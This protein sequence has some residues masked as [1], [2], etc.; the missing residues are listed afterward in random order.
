MK[1]A[2]LCI[3]GALALAACNK[4]PEVNLKNASGQQV[5]NAVSQSGVISGDYMIQPGEWASQ[6]T[7]QEMSFPGMPPQFQDQMK[8]AISARESQSSKRCVSPEDAKK[9]K[10]DFF[11]G[12]D[13]NCRFGHFTMGHGKMDIQMVCQEERATRTSNMTGSFTPTGYSMEV[14]STVSGGEQSGAVMKMHVDAKRI[15]NC[16]GKDS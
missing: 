1:R 14:S 11:A 8:K 13:K 15:G 5:A 3:A 2:G 4:G 9:P 7:I 6:V 10:E 16:S 12:Q